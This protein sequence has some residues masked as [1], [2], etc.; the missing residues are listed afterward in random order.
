MRAALLALAAVFGA[1]PALADAFMAVPVP[2]T[3]IY[4][5]EVLTGP[6][7]T[8]RRYRISYVEKNP[9]ARQAADIVGKAATRTLPKGRPVLLSHLGAAAAVHEGEMVTAEFT[10]GALRIQTRMLAMHA[11]AIGMP[12]SLRNVE[13]GAVVS[14]FV[15]ADGVVAVA[16]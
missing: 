13:T 6:K 16:P 8:E 14:G 12:I 9:F 1:S 5:G 4:A 10:A 7:L 11:A 2:A 3:T 15:R